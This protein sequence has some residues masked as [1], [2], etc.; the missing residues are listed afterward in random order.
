MLCLLM[1]HTHINHFENR[2]LKH[3]SLNETGL[4][5]TYIRQFHK[6]LEE[7]ETLELIELS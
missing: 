4:C 5:T 3:L 6:T 2:T 1:T 7:S